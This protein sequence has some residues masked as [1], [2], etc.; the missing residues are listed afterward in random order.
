MR[1]SL[2][3]HWFRISVLVGAMIALSLSTYFSIGGVMVQSMITF[4]QEGQFRC[5]DSSV[6]DRS[7]ECP[8]SDQCPSGA[9][10]TI[11]IQC[12]RVGTN[13]ER[14][15]KEQLQTNNVDGIE[16]LVTPTPTLNE[17]LSDNNPMQS[18]LGETA[19]IAIFTNKITY[20]LGEPI[21]ITVENNGT[22][23]LSLDKNNY[24]KI[25]DL[26]TG[27]NYL[28]SSLSSGSTL[29]PNELN[30]FTWNQKNSKAEQLNVGKYSASVDIGSISVNVM[31]SIVPK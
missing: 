26:Q 5:T 30:Q 19:S 6:V 20:A 31:F 14:Q 13:G 23:P 27:K 11:L 22:V 3:A 25:T 29:R 16:P 15:E 8:S 1:D 2:G 10:G 18:G 17:L 9:G 28:A 7:S 24:V 4:E 21:T 12:I